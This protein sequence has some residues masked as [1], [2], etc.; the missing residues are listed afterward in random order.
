MKYWVTP[1]I[2]DSMKRRARVS[3]AMYFANWAARSAAAT[4]ISGLQAVGV[5]SK[6]EHAEVGSRC[7]KREPG[8]ATD[9][10]LRDG[11]KDDEDG[12]GAFRPGHVGLVDLAELRRRTA[13][14]PLAGRFRVG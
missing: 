4:A 9:H 14:G 10:G 2:A 11:Q 12:V 3:L 7:G 5:H 6:E 8:E 13:L 1:T